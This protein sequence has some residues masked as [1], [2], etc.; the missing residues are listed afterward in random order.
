VAWIYQG[1][2]RVAVVREVWWPVSAL[3]HASFTLA[4]MTSFP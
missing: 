3:S 1:A 4:V 2:G